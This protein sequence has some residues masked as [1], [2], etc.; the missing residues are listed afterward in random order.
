MELKFQEF[1]QYEIIRAERHQ[2]GFAVIMIDL[3]N[4]KYINDTFGHPIGDM[5]LKELTAMLAD[6]L[7]KGDV[8]AR[9]GGDEFAIILPDTPAADGLLVAI[10]AGATAVIQP[11]GSMR[12]AEVIKAADEHNVAMVFTGT[13]HFRH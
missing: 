7:R 4:F 5:V 6:G 12:D 3:D 11:G 13:R 10:E 9:M 8:L 1:L 2:Y